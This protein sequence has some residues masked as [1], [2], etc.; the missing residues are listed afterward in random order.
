MREQGAQRRAYVEAAGCLGTGREVLTH[1]RI[2]ERG[3]GKKGCGLLKSRHSRADDCAGIPVRLAACQ[4]CR[5]QY[6]VTAATVGRFTCACGADV[7]T[8]SPVAVDAAVRR[9]GSCG[10]G[11]EPDAAQCG[12]CRSAIERDPGRLGLVCPECYGRTTEDSRF[13]TGCGVE[14]RPQP[15]PGS[16]PVLA[17]PGCTRDM[18]ARTIA[19]TLVQECLACNG[20]WV[21]ADAF[22][23]LV[24]RAAGAARRR[25]THGLG[26]DAPHA[27]TI[28]TRVVYRCCPVC[29]MQM[30]RRNFGRTSG[31]I[32]DWCGRH[33]TWLDADELEQVA[34]FVLAGG[35][36]TTP[37]PAT[38]VE[39][40]AQALL[41][42]E[43]M[44]E[45]DRKQRRNDSLLSILLKFIG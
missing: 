43:R 22:D 9:C 4:A 20:M 30:V 32:V 37:S 33:G 45:D 40:R 39:E 3:S 1:R 38:Q 2:L 23:T 29:R 15:M 28:D 36:D 11:L 27:R 21:T 19:G 14:F 13:C 35:L 26:G 42:L 41:A 7:E 18:T 10:A 25:P 5:T 16:V 17:C 8:A 44:L 12:Y 6:D 34:A 31:V 24:K